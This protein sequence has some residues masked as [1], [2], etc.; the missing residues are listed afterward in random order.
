MV[1]KPFARIVVAV[2]E[3][4]PVPRNAS[5]EDMVAIRAEMQS[6]LEALIQESKAAVVDAT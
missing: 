3:P 6:A 5:P 1:P 4:L 2:G